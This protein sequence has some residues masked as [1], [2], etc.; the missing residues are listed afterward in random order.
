[1]ILSIDRAFPNSQP[2][3]IAPNIGNDYRCPHV[4]ETGLL[5]LPPSRNLTSI[6]DRILMHL[7]DAQ[8][9]FSYTEDKK[10]KEFE[11]EFAAYWGRRSTHKAALSLVTPGRKSREIFY[12]YDIR[13]KEYIFADDK[14]SLEKWLCNKGIRSESKTIMPTWLFQLPRPWTPSEFPENGHDITC[15]L[16]DDM[17]RKYVVP[18]MHAPFLFE[19]PTETGMTFASVVIHG[20][21]K[22][23]IIRGFRHISKV[24]VKLITDSCAKRAVE[25]HQV[26]RVD[27]RWVHGRD[28]SSSF[29]FLRNCKV[30]VVGCGS[31]GA[32]L[33]RLLAQAGVGEIMLVDNDVLSSANISR[34]VLGLGYVGCSKSL[35]LQLE[36]KRQFPHLAFEHAFQ[37]K[38]EYLSDKE[39]RCL[40]E[41]NIVIG[42]GIDFDG[43]SALD[44]WR[45]NLSRPPAYISTWVEAYAVVGHAVLLYG[46]TSILTGFDEQ[47]RP[48]FRLTDWPEEARALF[49]EAGCGNT[50]QPH[51]V[52]DLHPTIGVAAGLALGVLLGKIPISCRRLWV[53]DLTIVEENGG[54]LRSDIASKF[55]MHEFSWP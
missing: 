23:E 46:N 1:L 20:A 33:A 19:V 9:L 50:F 42:A 8:E 12:F 37:K 43:E 21:S 17:V 13:A 40:A 6:A 47:E 5:C 52:V 24:P 7:K 11:R 16:S 32:S 22:K 29:D 45:T 48:V 2:R 49:V 31:I 30:A 28:H 4:E 18:T 38:F 39:R 53:G 15:R 54:I 41:S 35:A 34:H 25:R 27:G 51:G 36:L 10:R 44:A 3:I 26:Q 55:T 14:I